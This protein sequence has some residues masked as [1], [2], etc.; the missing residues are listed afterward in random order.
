MVL[1][2][3]TRMKITLQARRD[4]DDLA[5]CHALEQRFKVLPGSLFIPHRFANLRAVAVFV[6]L[7]SM[8]LNCSRGYRIDTVVFGRV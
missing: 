4:G 8:L 2:P 7:S 1:S 6:I 5:K 3:E